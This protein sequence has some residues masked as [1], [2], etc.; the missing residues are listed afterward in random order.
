MF[1]LVSPFS[2][3]AYGSVFKASGPQHT[4]SDVALF[5]HTLL[6]QQGILL[7]TFVLSSRPL[8]C[9]AS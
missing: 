9:D 7:S 5:I 4:V 6:T 1:P 2:G 8:T 3:L